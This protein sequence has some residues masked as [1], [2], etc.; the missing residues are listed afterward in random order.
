VELLKN[1]AATVFEKAKAC[2]RLAV[3][4]TK[5]AVPAL[6]ALLPDENLNAYARFAL[7]GIADPAADKALRDAVAEQPSNHDYAAERG[8]FRMR[9]KRRAPYSSDCDYVNA[10]LKGRQLVGA[11]D[12]IG[13]RRDAKAVGVLQRLLDKSDISVAAAAAEALGRIGT[14][15]AASVLKA[16]IG[17]RS[18]VTDW[19]ADGC[20]TCVDSLVVDGK[21]SEAISLYGAVA[22]ADV[23]KH[24]KVAALAGQ[25]RLQQSAARDLLLAQIR[26]QD[27]AFFN[28]GLAVAREMPGAEVTAALAAEA[29]KLPPE[30]QALLLLAIGDRTDQAPPSLFL[31][32]SKSPAASVREA[33]IRVFINRGDVSAVEFLLDTALADATEAKIA[34]AGLKSLPGRVADAAIAARLAGAPAK[35]RVLLLELVGDRQLVRA[36]PAVR[37]AITE[38]DEP[39]RVAALAAFAQI[40]GPDDLDLLID[41]AFSPGNTPET[42]AARAALKTAVLRMADRNAC[43]EKLSERVECATVDQRTYLLDLLGQVSGPKAL[44]AVVACAKSGDPASKDAA[45][46]VLGEWPNAEAAPALLDIAKNDTEKKYRIR[47]LRGYIRIAR[48]LEIPWWIN[49]KADETKLTMFRSAMKAAQRNEEKLLA[50]DILT[51]IPSVTSLELAVSYLSE[52]ALKDAAADAAVKIAVKLVDQEPNAVS[53]A[54]QT[55]VAANVGSNLSSHAKQ[56]LGQANAASK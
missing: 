35:A 11:I 10:G 27:M 13:Q 29:E 47:A 45:T 19:I 14:A 26:S 9:A 12:S 28:L 41:K 42:T 38:A 53:E 3:V 33:A 1:P 32:A 44:D 20:L 7:E 36:A 2:Q 56:L 43:A 22:E 46:R 55:V 30:R 4:G 21:T 23:P 39:V 40:A 15:E 25:F 50:L 17:R 24:L 34:I 54:M 49:S 8:F 16:A 48:Q 31:A 5:D 51:R 18:A 6:A 37:E 52:P